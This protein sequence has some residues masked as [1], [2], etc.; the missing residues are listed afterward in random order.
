MQIRI[1]RSS[2]FSIVPI[3]PFDCGIQ[4][5]AAPDGY[6]PLGKTSELPDAFAKALEHCE[7]TE[8]AY[9]KARSP[10]VAP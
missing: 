6:T 10:I 8:A 9:R 2:E 5:F 1:G 3:L 7:S 4:M